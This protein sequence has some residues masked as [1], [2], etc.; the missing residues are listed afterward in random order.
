[1]P[2]VP[3]KFYMLIEYILGKKFI[4]LYEDFIIHL[5]LPGAAKLK[6]IRVRETSKKKKKRKQKKFLYLEDQC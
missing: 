2:I 5:I 6:R 3:K 4:V 1:M